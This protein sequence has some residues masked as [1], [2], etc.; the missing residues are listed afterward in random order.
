M[1]LQ[2]RIDRVVQKGNVKA[3][4]TIIIRNGRRLETAGKRHQRQARIWKSLLPVRRW[5]LA[6]YKR[7]FI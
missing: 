6:I 4:A 7:I 2:A 1:K 3:I 5:L